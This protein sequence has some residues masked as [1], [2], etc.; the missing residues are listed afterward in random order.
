MPTN[1]V[2]ALLVA[3][4]Q[5]MEEG[6]ENRMERYRSLAVQLRKGL[7]EAGM[8]PFTPDELMNPVLTAARPPRAWKAAGS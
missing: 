3:L 6:I 8:E 7:R 5:L 1:N 4:E 2:N